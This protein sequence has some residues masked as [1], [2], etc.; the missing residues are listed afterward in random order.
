M[1]VKGIRSFSKQAS[2]TPLLR[3]HFFL[4]FWCR[5][6]LGSP[7]PQVLI[8]CS[9]QSCQYGFNFGLTAHAK[10]KTPKEPLRRWL[11]QSTELSKENIHS[12]N[13]SFSSYGATQRTARLAT[14][15]TNNPIK[16][17]ERIQ[18]S[19]TIYKL[20]LPSSRDIHCMYN[21]HTTGSKTR[22]KRKHRRTNQIWPETNH[23]HQLKITD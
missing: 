21:N 8:K 12:N 19:L 2:T 1:A 18:L 15:F 5:L 7:M 17:Y 11:T 6:L 13:I 14:H 4:S 3:P 22:E 16:V 23:L 10:P 9:S 20:T